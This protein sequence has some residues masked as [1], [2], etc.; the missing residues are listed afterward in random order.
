MSEGY[1]KIIPYVNCENEHTE[2][3]IRQARSYENN[4]ADALFLYSHTESEE[5]RESFLALVKEVVRRVD[6]PVMAGCRVK[7]FEDIKKA[8]YTGAKHVVVSYEDVCGSDLLKQGCERFGKDAM[9]LEVNL[10][11]EALSGYFE[12]S[13]VNRA[14]Y[15]GML[16]FKHVDVSEKLKNSIM[17][18]KV[19]VIIR[20]SLIRNDM[21]TLIS[22]DNVFGVATNFYA[23]KT[24][25]SDNLYTDGEDIPAGRDIMKVKRNLKSEGISVDIFESSLSFAD[26]AKNSDGMVPCIVQDYRNDEVLMLAYMNEEAFNKTIETGIMTYFSRS[27]QELWIKGGTSGHFQYVKEL[28]ADCDKDTLLAKVNQVGAACHTGN[29]SCFFNGLLKHEYDEKNA[30]AVLSDLYNV[31]V[32]RKQNP[33]EGSYTNY[34]LDKG[35]DKIL[36]KCGEE[37][38]EMVIAAKNPNAEELKYEIADLLYHMTV[39]MV[40]C[41]V[42]WED[43]VEE[44][45]KR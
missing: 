5:E 26:L 12:D 36:K 13:A 3:V 25:P 15:F 42:D 45:A 23:E 19:P 32:D 17:S 21:E 40:E 4:G 7:R 39:L 14:D 29:R 38:T 44:L 27:R 9:V 1:R 41:G 33:K 30:Y 28:K 43:V 6:I 37:A 10:A 16:L 2:K 20:D 18:Q 34:L 11:P 22:M 8:F 24:L 31:V 35:I